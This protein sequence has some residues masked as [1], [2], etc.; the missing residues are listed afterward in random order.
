MWGLVASIGMGLLGRRDASK[1]EDRARADA[2]ASRATALKDEEQR[3]VRLREAAERGGF[4]PLTVLESGFAGSALPS[5]Y[6]SGGETAAF[7]DM[8]SNAV[9]S[10]VDAYQGFQAAK[11]DARR[12][13]V[14]ARR[15]AVDEGN[16]ALDRERLAL[17]RETLA[18]R[19]NSSPYGPSHNYRTGPLLGS[20]A[21]GSAPSSAGTWSGAAP[22]SGLSGA[23]AIA[24]AVAAYTTTGLEVDENGALIP[25]D[26]ATGGGSFVDVDESV[27]DADDWET[28]YSEPGG[29]IGAGIAATADADHAEADGYFGSDNIGRAV[30]GGALAVGR[31]LAPWPFNR[32]IPQSPSR[33][34]GEPRN[35]AYGFQPLQSFQPPRQG[36]PSYGAPLS[37]GTP[38]RGGRPSYGP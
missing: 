3:F 11:T 37:F 23:F 2:K 27:S 17:E 16:L 35:P 18:A 5:G 7:G 13:A 32:P 25:R 31:R 14:D 28:R 38:S 8:R 34:A 22:P 15:A 36:R 29:W 26:I 6:L 20:S 10:A 1:A 9:R 24:P 30:L 21:G 12:A 4:N 33:A 19:I